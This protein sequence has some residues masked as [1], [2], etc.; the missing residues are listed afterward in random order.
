MTQDLTTT[1][2]AARDASRRHAW[3]ETFDLLSAADAIESLAPEDLEGLGNAAWWLGQLAACISARERSYAAHVAAG[4]AQRAA[5]V[6]IELSRAYVQKGDSSV[7][8][9][10]LSRAE[11]LP[12]DQPESLAHGSLTRMRCVVAFEGQHDFVTALALA[13]RALD[14]GTRFQDRDLMAIAL[15]DEGRIL[16]AKGQVAKGMALID[17]A[18]MAAVS[19]EIGPFATAIVYCNTI[20]ACKDLTDYL[21]AREWTEAAKRWCERQAIAGFPGMCR[22]YRAGI[23]RL[24]GALS[25]A[26]AEARRACEELR[27]FSVGYRA[28]ALYELGEIRLRM[29]DLTSAEDAFRQA[30]ELGRNP[31]PGLSLLR[32][33]EGKTKA[34]VASIRRALVEPSQDRLHRAHLLP[35]R[36]ETAL[37]AGDLGDA[38][39]A[40]DELEEIA[41]TFGT[42]A[43]QA[44]AAHAR[45]AVQLAQADQ[46]GAERNLRQS[47]HLWQ[48]VDCPYE[49][50]RARVLLAAAYRAQG[51]DEAAV[52]ELRAAKTTFERLGARLDLRQVMEL[53]GA[54]AAAP[55]A[56]ER[57]SRTL[58]FTDIVKSTRLVE[59]VGDTAWEDLTRWHDDT[60]RSLFA[61]HRGEEIDHAGDGFFVAFENQAAAIECAVAIQRAL[62]EHRRKHGFAPQVRIGLHAT[63]ARRRGTVYRGKGIHEAARIAA[64]AE[65]DQI[66]ASRETATVPPSGVTASEP[67]LVTLRGIVDPVEVVTITWR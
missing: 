19:G 63:A 48:E 30:H 56:G 61:A 33:A 41:R 12:H 31:E 22:V 18:T 10:W 15:H 29:G 7:G 55:A 59:A 9:A 40:T 66:V 37:A 60:L 13:K 67:R 14:I 2:V 64:L 21:R 24:R 27:D 62:A 25:E 17:E 47:A 4:N 28:E 54:E 45:G 3:R 32:L 36:V 1:L 51:D 50:A 16:V 44:S 34:A 42:A 58:M 11:R 57:I 26:D 39:A 43:L 52:L 8:M 46:S 35:A 65:G 23:M 49:S 6:A 53:L 5:L 20:V 38:E